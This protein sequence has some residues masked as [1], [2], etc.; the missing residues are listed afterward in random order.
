ME[1]M[2]KVRKMSVSVGDEVLIISG[3]DKGKKGIV[4]K[5]FP[6]TFSLS[7]DKVN[8]CK[9]SVRITQGNNDNFVFRER[10]IHVSNVKLLKKN[11][12]KHT[13]TSKKKNISKTKQ[14]ADNV[15]GESVKKGIFGLKM[16]DS[17]KTEGKSLTSKKSSRVG[18]LRRKVI[19]KSG[20]K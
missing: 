16:A 14:L 5:V 11:S 2:Y 18:I 4:K 8:V 19:S 9:K 3:K 15:S 12:G 10:P 7:I 17:K 1:R 13:S 6:K 20:G